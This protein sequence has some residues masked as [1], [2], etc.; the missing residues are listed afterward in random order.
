MLSSRLAFTGLVAAFLA[1]V[2]IGIWA[3]GGGGG[4]PE[5]TPLHGFCA[6]DTDLRSDARADP[7]G[8]D[9]RMATEH[10]RQRL[11]E[12]MG[13][14][15]AAIADDVRTLVGAIREF[16]HRAFTDPAVQASADR[17]AAWERT[18]C[19]RRITTTTVFPFPS[20]GVP[21]VPFECPPGFVLVEDPA[22]G[23]RSLLDLMEMT[24]QYADTAELEAMI[25]EQLELFDLYGG[26]G[27]VTC[28]PRDMTAV[29]GVD[30]ESLRE[31]FEEMYGR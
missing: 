3:F 27:M 11:D 15:P 21:G 8:F 7:V 4:L 12:M 31:Y 6:L 28:M 16:G 19:D 26:M 13:R 23:H 9:E 30:P 18:N 1:I 29:E 14:A 25:R 5:P 22:V 10:G 17:I 20:G 24:G 2:A